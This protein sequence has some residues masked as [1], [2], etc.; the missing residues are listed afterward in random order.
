VKFLTV[1]F[2]SAKNF[3]R[4]F[5]HKNPGE[6]KDTIFYLTFHRN[7]DKIQAKLTAI[8]LAKKCKNQTFITAVILAVITVFLHR[9]IDRSGTAAQDPEGSFS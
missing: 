6:K 7:L 8:M 5:G 1:I 9:R 3:I 2:H 4:F